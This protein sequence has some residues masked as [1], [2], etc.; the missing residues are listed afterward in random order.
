[1]GLHVGSCLSRWKTPSRVPSVAWMRRN[2]RKSE[3]FLERGGI[4]RDCLIMKS[5]A[6][7]FSGPQI[8][9]HCQISRQIAVF[10]AR[11]GIPNPVAS[12]PNACGSKGGV[13]NDQPEGQSRGC[14]CGLRTTKATVG[15]APPF[16]LVCLSHS[17]E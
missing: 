7:G 2:R 6:G 1:M 10:L 3:Y 12:R 14:T 13:A 4:D 5:G 16:S 15:G 8:E 17:H 9:H 11:G